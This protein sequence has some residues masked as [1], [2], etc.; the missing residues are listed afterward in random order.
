MESKHF[1]TAN[2][3]FREKLRGAC[4]FAAD[5]AFCSSYTLHFIDKV[6]WRGIVESI[7]HQIL[8]FDWNPKAAIRQEGKF[9]IKAQSTATE[10]A[11]SLWIN[12]IAASVRS[13]ELK[14]KLVSPPTHQ[15]L[16]LGCLLGEA[17]WIRGKEPCKSRS[18]QIEQLVSFEHFAYMSS[19]I[20]RWDSLCVFIFVITG[21][22]EDWGKKVSQLLTHSHAQRYC[23]NYTQTVAIIVQLRRS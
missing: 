22:C 15:F 21:E 11:E 16:S 17:K 23:Y 19:P 3:Q 2:G 1:Q 5:M 12:N 13:L 9:R 14:A 20:I 7:T 8:I 6:K 18:F 10:R 4:L